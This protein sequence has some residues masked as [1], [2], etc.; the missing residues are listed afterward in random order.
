MKIKNL[1][2]G[3]ACAAVVVMAAAPAAKA[4]TGSPTDPYSNGATPGTGLVSAVV[5]QAL[6]VFD[7]NCHADSVIT[8]GSDT[9]YS[10][11]QRLTT[12]YNASEGLTPQGSAAGSAAVNGAGSLTCKGAALPVGTPTGDTA[13]GTVGTDPLASVVTSENLDHDTML[14][15][16]PTGS[17]NGINAVCNGVSVTGA[18]IPALARSS[19]VRNAGE[20][21]NQDFWGYARDAVP[22]IAWPT[23]NAG[24]A[25]LAASGLTQGQVR[26][27]FVDCT[28]TSWNQIA[29][30]LPATP[31]KIW[32]I[33]SN[34]GTFATF[35]AYAT[36]GGI[37]GRNAN[38]CAE[39]QGG[40]ARD[41]SENDASQIPVADRGDSIWGMSFGANL[42]LPRQAAGSTLLRLGVVGA[43]PGAANI[44]ATV[45]TIRNATATG[46]PTGRYLWAVV[47]KPTK[48]TLSDSERA[49]MDFATWLCK[50]AA[51][52]AVG[53]H[54]SLLGA[55]YGLAANTAIGTFERFVTLSDGTGSAGPGNAT[56]GT[57]R[58]VA[59]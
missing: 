24:L 55:D 30:A 40:L 26:Q 57:G 3:A 20:C 53:G 13:I 56:V 17:G 51:A 47:A 52:G 45:A 19:R 7:T 21:P 18:G 32:G 46:Y 42:S 14:D 39:A 44:A 5:G 27:I 29:P 9:T 6:S 10:L 34:S 43:A 16:F 35:N 33:Q 8:M 2:V 49:A 25:P 38:F 12:I 4:A 50:P 22:V 1:L 58:C 31:I 54:T 36:V 11:H 28:I 23:L 41:L 59:G 48:A 37:A 15:L